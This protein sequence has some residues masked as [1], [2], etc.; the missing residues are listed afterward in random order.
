MMYRHIS[1][2]SKTPQYAHNSAIL[3]GLKEGFKCSEKI[4]KTFGIQKFNYSSS[5]TTPQTFLI[6]LSA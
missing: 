2:N 3:P 6:P 4:L 1:H 5:Y